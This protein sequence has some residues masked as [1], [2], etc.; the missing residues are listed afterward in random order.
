MVQ[1]MEPQEGVSI[2][3]PTVGSSGILIQS[4]QHA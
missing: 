2:Y 3:D 4:K 1:L